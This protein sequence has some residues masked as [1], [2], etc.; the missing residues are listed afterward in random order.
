MSSRTFARIAVLK[1]GPS[2]EREV[3][4][5]SGRDCAAALRAGGYEVIEIDAG[6]RIVDD[7][8]AARPDAVFN[9]LH[10]RWG[11]DGCIQGLLEWLR[12]PYSHSG[13]LASALAMDKTRSKDVFRAAGLPV[14]AGVLYLFGGPLLNPMVASLAM[15]FSS[16]SVIA[17]ALRLRRF[18][19]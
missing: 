1:G 14:A 10:G 17:N 13:V 5:V 11:E 8:R 18:K 16:V 2:A 15:A 19:A 3:S 9:A 12:I 4:L 6:E 7:L